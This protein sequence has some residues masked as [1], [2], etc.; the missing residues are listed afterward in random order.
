MCKRGSQSHTS[1]RCQKLAASG[2]MFN[3]SVTALMSFNQS[4]QSG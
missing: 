3:F 4:A 1:K 2:S